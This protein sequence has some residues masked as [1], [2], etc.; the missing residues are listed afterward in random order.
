MQGIICALEKALEKWED[1]DVSPRLDVT[2][3]T[4]S[5]YAANCMNDWIYKWSDNGWINAAGNEV[6]NRDL[7]QEAS[8]LDDE[9]NEL[10]SVTYEWIPRS[11]NID[12]D[13]ACNRV[14]D[15]MLD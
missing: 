14:L 7:I 12:A 6:A 10:G 1:L 8:N 3:Y 11:Q 5:K 13:A 9:L 2:I 15:E 4:D